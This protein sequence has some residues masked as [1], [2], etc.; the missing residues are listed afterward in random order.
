MSYLLLRLSQDLLP[1]ESRDTNSR[2]CVGRGKGL[3]KNEDGTVEH[4]K[5]K[6]KSDKIG[7]SLGTPRCWL[8]QR[9]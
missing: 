8:E 9:R 6:K 2:S 4:V 3:G 7:V 5:V 1:P